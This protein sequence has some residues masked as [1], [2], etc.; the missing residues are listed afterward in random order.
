MTMISIGLF[1]KANAVNQPN[2]LITNSF[3]HPGIL[4][5]KADLDLIKNNQTIEPWKSSLDALKATPAGSLSYSIQGPFSA[6]YRG[7]D[8]TTGWVQHGKD[9]QACYVQS[10][11]WYITGN[12]TY[13]S[14]AIN[15]ANAWSSTL[16]SVGGADVQLLVGIQGPLWAMA[17]EILANSGVD[18][19]WAS[20]DITRTKDMLTN[21]FLPAIDGFSPDD[22]ANFS[23]SCMFA[24]MAIA[25]FTDNQTKFDATWNA[26]IS[27]D[28]CPNDYS[29]YKNIASNGQN[30][31]SGRD[32]VHSWSSYEMLSGLAEI[33]YNQGYDPYTLGSNRLMTGVEYWCKY[34]LGNTVPYNT[35]VYRCRAGWGP[36]SQI[37]STSRGTPTEQGSVCNLVYRAY[38]RLD[39]TAPYTKQVADAMGNIMVPANSRNGWGDPF[40][41]D[42]LLYVLPT[43]NIST[44]LTPVA[45]TYVNGGA[46]TTNYGTTTS[47]ITKTSSTDRYAYLKFDLSGVSGSITS[48]KLKLFTKSLSSASTRSV[49]A[50]SND[51]WSETDITW[52]NKPSYG[53]ELS[54]LNITSNGAYVEWDITS[55]INSEYTGDKTASLC[56][57]DPVSNNDTGIDFY[58]KEN[59]SNTPVLTIITETP[60]EQSVSLSTT[61]GNDYVNL[62]WALINITLDHQD[63]FRD[64][65]PDP[66]GR[67]M[68]AGA[69]NGNNYTDNTVTSGTTYYYWIKATSTDGTI[70][71]SSAIS[72]TTSTTNI[73]STNL[74]PVADTYVNGGAS[75][76][77]YGTT[78]SMI[79]KTSSTDRYAYL[80]FD[81]SG[82]S[83]SITSAKLKLFTKSLSSA[84]TR[85][86]YALSNDSWSETD[87]TWNNK[88]SY[89]SE[90]SNLNITSNGAYVEWDITS[91]INSEYTGDKTASLCVNDP[92]SNND[93]GIDFYSKENGSNTPVLTII[94]ETPSEQSVSLST[95][96][97]NDYVNL[98][99]ALINITLDHQD[100]FRDTDPDPNGRIMIAGAVN[101]NNYTDNTVTS[102]TTYYYWIKATST[103]G[104][105]INSSAISTTTTGCV[106]TTIIPYLQIDGGSWSQG[107]TAS[108]NIGQTIKF[109]PQPTTAGS[110]SWSGPNGYSASTREITI[111]NSQSGNYIAT[112]TNNST[113]EST[114]TFTIV[115]NNSAKTTKVKSISNSNISNK[116]FTIFPNPLNGNKL[117]IQFKLKKKSQ[118]I[119]VYI[120]S[121]TGKQVMYVNLGNGETGI[122]NKTIKIQS[123]EKGLYFIKV[124]LEN[125][126]MTKKLV[127]E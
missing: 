48:A 86:V 102:G 72:A 44:N 73:T 60:S 101:G 108:I 65:D 50:L 113:C 38:K 28:G 15:I 124:L 19:G 103:D 42:A 22:G 74:T 123:I 112:Y 84:S 24:T 61:T 54:N 63:I 91:Y 87:I 122:F 117:N 5:T 9:A 97:G 4:S 32:Q 78:T 58:S 94:T 79:T 67:I 8:N 36:W 109:G 110:W 18:S 66:N 30:V 75:T 11:L 59:G 70:I 107:S 39:I 125:T 25:V 55:Y 88:P 126:V 27:T 116:T 100:I 46:S 37:S 119:I 89:G 10:L 93:T 64:T 14:N 53:S 77:N 114:Q 2:I 43:T 17:G 111:S 26:F 35:T 121:I 31:E 81:L 95:T 104:T 47:M 82:V 12:S 49:Y 21:I 41:A 118:N 23:T 1:N 56:V 90:L 40:I 13:A 96:T 7:S 33:A 127:I 34:N 51:S 99:W 85:S 29:L 20:A 80:K 76:T 3:N 71:N 57:N 105:I 69:V 98:N 62:N 52:N 83:G 16:T 92:V 106:P 45:D 68:I 115:L 6:I 120:Y